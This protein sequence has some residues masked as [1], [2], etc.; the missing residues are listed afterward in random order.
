M[1][2]AATPLP[3]EETTPPVTNIYFGAIRIARVVTR[4]TTPDCSYLS[5]KPVVTPVSQ[6]AAGL[7]YKQLWASKDV[8]SIRTHRAAASKIVIAAQLFHQG[9]VYAGRTTPA[10]IGPKYS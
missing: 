9:R 3:S 10:E 4:F 5:G 1:E 8:L 2:E 7:T 6:L